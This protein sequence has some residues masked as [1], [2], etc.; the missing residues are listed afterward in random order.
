[1]QM[2][3]LSRDRFG[4]SPTAAR[5]WGFVFPVT[6]S[7]L[8]LLFGA[9]GCGSPPPVSSSSERGTDFLA[10]RDSLGLDE[11]L[12]LTTEQKEQ[13][14][15]LARTWLAKAD[16]DSRP[17]AGIASL[18][19][20]AGLTPDD[21]EIWLRLAHNQRWFSDYVSTSESLEKA[22]AAVRKLGPE[23]SNQ[24]KRDAQR[25]TA[26]A[27]A[28]LHYDRGEYHEALRWV[29][30]GADVSPGDTW[31]RQIMG[32]VE[33]SLNQRS[34]AHEVAGDMLRADS[35]DPDAEWVLGVLDRADGRY[36]EAFNYL[37]PLRPAHE[38]S[39]E[40]YRD[41]GEVAEK[42]GEWSYARRWYAE[43]AHALPF[44]DTS[45]L[46]EIMYDRLEPGPEKSRQPVWVASGR[47]YTTGS[48]S[49]YAALAMDRFD[50]ADDPGEREFWAG[51]VVDATG[52]LLRKEMHRPWTLRARGL[53]FIAKGLTERGLKDLRQASRLLAEKG[54]GDSRI[55]ATIGHT[56]LLSEDHEAARRHLRRAVEM[57]Q[58]N[59]QA[60][61]DLGLCQ[62]MA[63]HRNAADRA[64]TRAIE[65]QPDLAAAW[66][67]RGLMNLHEGNLDQAEQDLVQ[68][69]KLAPGNPE[70]TK[71][72]QQVKLRRR[73]DQ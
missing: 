8:I 17:E 38:H 10:A 59:A 11:F 30:A 14:R 34:Q 32:L 26:L 42:L 68:A 71:L 43:S 2:V 65:I 37:A 13:R 66:Y 47:Y 45:S 41:K 48:L 54:Q 5:R 72:L 12:S 21:P 52:V 1:L 67:N 28:W 56:L 51:Q 19:R 33:G 6:M 15:G 57:D 3:S 50:R 25:N 7:V 64:L 22:A 31:V 16:S 62:I 40:C 23:H 55:E 49:A 70:V 27:R 58:E 4:Q 61:S 36:R 18:S 24:E 63:G 9:G 39:A 53:V 35:G 29:R 46:Q 69:A 20:A 44:R 60:W 73:Q